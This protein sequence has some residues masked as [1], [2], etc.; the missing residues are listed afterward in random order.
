MKRFILFLVLSLTL[1][2]CAS[3]YTHYAMFPAANSSGEPRQI[4]L[5]WQTAD[6]PGW[7]FVSDK[8][9]PMRVET[10]CS[11]R[12]WRLRDDGDKAACGQGIRACGEP[13]RDVYASGGSL[14]AGDRPCMTVN[15]SDPG[16]RI[17]DVGEK[18]E[19]LVSCRPVSPVEG[20][21]DNLRN[22]DYLRASAVPYTV[23]ARKAP[24]GSLRA[25]MP[26]FDE[27]VCDAE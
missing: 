21:G 22:M 25:K 20:Q 24:R 23:Y 2:G 9:T 27:S 15:P 5:S 14:A 11:D 3:Y 7:W 12:V 26:E 18:F 8:A 17:P 16:A 19:L 1:P 6:Y 10:Q 4:R 13:V